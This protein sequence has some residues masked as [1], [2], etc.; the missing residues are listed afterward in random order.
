MNIFL[1]RAAEYMGVKEG[2]SLGKSDAKRLRAKAKK[3]KKSCKK[4]LRNE[5]NYI[6]RIAGWYNNY[7]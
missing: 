5:D 7:K 4:S 2:D 3:M 1:R 6:T